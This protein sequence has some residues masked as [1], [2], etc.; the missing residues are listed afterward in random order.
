MKS[1]DR[2]PGHAQR[3]CKGMA[4]SLLAAC[5]TAMSLAGPAAAQ[6][7]S[8]QGLTPES[9]YSVK[10]NK[11]VTLDLSA[12]PSYARDPASR[13]PLLSAIV[14][15]E[16][17]ALVNY[18]G[19]IPGLPATSPKATGA[20]KVNPRSAAVRSYTAH[21]RAKQAAFEASAAATSPSMK[22]SQRFT[23]A[24]NGIALAAT[25]KD[26]QAIANLEGVVA[27][28]PDELRQLNTEVSPG[29]VGAETVWA[30]LGG[31][32]SAGEGVIVGVL[33]SG[34][35]PEHPSFADPDPSGTP[36]PAPADTY[37]CEFGSASPGDAPFDCNNKLIGA[38]RF[39]ATYD[40]F[41]P[42]LLPG[43]FVSARDDDG[44]GTHT[45]TTAAGNAGV[46]VELL[47]VWRGE[48]SGVAPRAH[49]IAYKVCG[50]AG[51]FQ[52]DSVAAIDQA[53]IDGVD[54]INFSIS[55]GTNPYADTVSL[56]FL[57]A[58]ANG[59][60]VATSAGNAGPGANTVGHRG[61]WTTTV[62]ASTSSRH[63]LSTLTLAAD[64]GHE[65][66][67]VGASITAGISDPTPVVFPPA[68]QELC[69][70]PFQPG[71][72][73]GEIVICERGEIARVEKGYNVQVGGAAG[74]IQYNPTLQGL[75]TDN[76][77]IP[78]I[79]LE[80]EAGGQLLDFMT[81]YTGVTATFTDGVASIVQG[82]VMAGFSS[83][84]GAGLALGIAKPDITAPGVQ[85]LAGHTP[86]PATV[87]GGKP[88]ELF[89]AIQGT[90]MSSPHVAGAGA[91]LR[92]LHPEW[93]PGQIKSALMTSALA[94]GVVKE[95]GVTP[96]DPFDFGSG[97]LDLN[98]AGD[99]GITVSASAS[100]FILLQ[101]RLWD[102]NYPSVYI[103][104]MPGLL[105]V[106]RTVRSELGTAT[107]WRSTVTSPPDLK[108]SVP[109]NLG[110][111]GGAEVTFRID[112]DAS[113]VQIGEVRHAEVEFQSG[114]KRFRMP[115]TVVRAQ[116]GA[117]LEKSCSP[118]TFKR[119][120]TTE[121]VVT[122]RNTELDP[123]HVRVTD[124][125]PNAIQLLREN[126]VGA[127]EEGNGWFFE[128]TLAGAAP[129]DVAI[130]AGAAPFGYF[131]LT[132]A[133]VA[134]VGDES[135]VN[136]TLP[137]T[138]EFQ[139]GGELYTRVG[140]VSNGYLVVGGGTAADVRF[141]NQ[142]F[143]DPNRPNNVLAPFWTDLNP[144]VGGTLHAQ[145][146]SAG[147]NLWTVF[148]WRA[149]PNW[150][151]P[152]QVNTFQVWLPASTNTGGPSFTNIAYAY[153]AALSAGDGGFLTVGAEN[154][155][156]N[157]GANLYFDGVGT[158]P[159]AGTGAIVTSTP[160]SEG[161]SHTITFQ[162]TG[163]RQANWTNCAEMTSESFPGTSTAC[164]SGTVT[165]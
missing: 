161:G 37:A 66:K 36:F 154:L 124:R 52:S 159:T 152:A 32:E 127:I 60:F 165:K 155:F 45:A 33:D 141:I 97:R 59:V 15:L 156:G 153:G 83:R 61:P 121:C 46:D 23:A 92:A 56:A 13:A 110:V 136:F 114:A 55:G 95:D 70:S 94:V 57:N 132:S 72:F 96:A 116:A 6:V 47:D 87:A 162:A 41:G 79:H 35:W 106:H 49:V 145:I 26:L 78:S 90:S 77:F 22:I 140:M 11:Q 40:V 20:R 147:S 81:A 109:R 28:Y 1:P 111:P 123:V 19:T 86:M 14:I 91:L 113:G 164:A 64:G 30:A 104:K 21:L 158:L 53:I 29:F 2:N 135:I 42:P 146:L 148:E 74:M 68:G 107:S 125:L 130:A 163:V 71:T 27:V 93:T 5:L 10:A 88:G 80:N 75:A 137:G 16:D 25:G 67:L 7:P 31:V 108:I 84:G 51:C 122:I 62:G 65:L 118:T 17:P 54:V 85:I 102:A 126:T 69:L 131:P 119:G 103:P 9:T 129:P 128:G 50:D 76:H 99:P 120:E 39:M 157:R 133:P 138:V 8:A 115:I 82:D 18:Q 134:G 38:H 143:P 3:A 48:V 100:D 160:P 149:V 150:S 58:Y 98:R 24:V 101:N 12:F 63:F 105:S 34:V 144:G 117:T 112:I 44:H 142:N 73:N 43:E 139:Y 89:Q 4:L 151:N